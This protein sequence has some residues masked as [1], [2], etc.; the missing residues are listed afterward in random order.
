MAV[1]LGPD[2][3]TLGSTTINDWAD[4]G[5]GYT[6]LGGVTTTSGTSQTLSGLDLSG[7]TFLRIV[8]NQVQGDSSGE[9]ARINGQR[10]N[11]YRSSIDYHVGFVQIELSTGVYEGQ[12]TSGGNST[13]EYYFAVV[14]SNGK[15]PSATLSASTTSL[16]FDW[17][18]TGLSFQHGSIKVYGI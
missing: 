14:P 10:I 9:M 16:T 6:Y 2:G 15:F 13:N 11:N 17:T 1:D 18:W 3:L 5:G 4:V 12:L 7:Y 8:Y